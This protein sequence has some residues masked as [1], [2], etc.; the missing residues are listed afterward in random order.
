MNV[1]PPMLQGQAIGHG[2]NQD[3][4]FFNLLDLFLKILKILKERWRLDSQD[5]VAYEHVSIYLY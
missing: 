4:G 3:V 2:S 5:T 1:E